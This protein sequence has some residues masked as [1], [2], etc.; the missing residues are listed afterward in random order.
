MLLGFGLGLNISRGLFTAPAPA[1]PVAPTL[2]GVTAF[3]TAAS[4]TT[5][6]ADYSDFALRQGDILIAQCISRAAGTNSITAPAGEGWTAFATSLNSGSSYVWFWK[7]WGAGDTDPTR[8]TST[9]TFATGGNALGAV[10]SIWRGC[11]ATG[12]PYS[13]VSAVTLAAASATPTS[14]TVASAV[15][16]GTLSLRFFA[17]IDDNTLISPS[18][19][20]VTYGGSSYNLQTALTGSVACVQEAD[21]DSSTVTCTVSESTNGNDAYAICTLVLDGVIPVADTLTVYPFATNAYAKSHINDTGWRSGVVTDRLVRS[22]YYYRYAVAV[23]LDQTLTLVSQRKTV[24]ETTWTTFSTY[25]TAV[26]AD[27]AGVTFWPGDAHF[28]P[29]LGVSKSGKLH[30]WFLA[31]AAESP[32]QHGVGTGPGDVTISSFSAGVPVAGISYPDAFQTA[33]GT[34]CFTGRLGTA[35]ND[36]QQCLYEQSA[37]ESAWIQITPAIMNFTDGTGDDES[38]YRNRM[39]LDP[40]RDELHVPWIWAKQNISSQYH[41]VQYVKGVRTG[42]GTWTWRA[43]NGSTITLPVLDTTAACQVDNGTVATPFCVHNGCGFDPATGYPIIPYLKAHTTS[44]GGG[45]DLV[46]ASWNG[47]TW[48]FATVLIHPT[49]DMIGA[50]PNPERAV[51]RGPDAAVTP[52]GVRRIIY[53]SDLELSS[54]GVSCLMQRTLSSDGTTLSAATRLVDLSFAGGCGRYDQ[55]ALTT[56]GKLTYYQQLNDDDDG[57]WLLPTNSVACI[58]DVTT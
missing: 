34:L 20:T 36:A 37:D 3:A 48:V 54:S 57:V 41:S 53:S 56:L 17:T 16:S 24:A 55:T 31:H 13:Q 38:P 21:V 40:E 5:R 25:T 52:D 19:G 26:I 49:W 4:G 11:K 12:N 7:R 8:Q 18:R 42:A 30:I 44:H 35:G 1:N 10:I 2:V 6:T 43:M 27:P 15:G 50:P 46:V 47:T 39:V 45:T 33:D 14:A 29:S 9:F 32:M 58:V 23:N 28:T 51:V 22:G